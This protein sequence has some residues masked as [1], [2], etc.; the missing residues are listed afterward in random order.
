[1]DQRTSASRKGG[2]L[3]SVRWWWVLV[4][5]T[6]VGVVSYLLLFPVITAYVVIL[7]LLNRAA[8]SSIDQFIFAYGALGMPTMH[9]LL[10]ALAASWVARRVG[11]AAVTHGVLI[12][13]V[14]VVVL[15]CILWY[16]TSR[17]N[18]S[19]VAT[20]LVM[21]LVGGLLGGFL[22]RSVVSR[23]SREAT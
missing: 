7:S 21:A 14:S 22:G 2:A 23:D 4:T 12:A 13:L 1:M 17:L 11:T 16:D 5:G 9:L 18:L 8:Q 6:G 10:T 3:G 20:L 15:Q 19:E